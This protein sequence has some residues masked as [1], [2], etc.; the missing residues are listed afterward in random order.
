M[1]VRCIYR[2]GSPFF[3]QTCAALRI[4]PAHAAGGGRTRWFAWNYE[5]LPVL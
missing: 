4:E 2:G 1:L 3:D 5:P